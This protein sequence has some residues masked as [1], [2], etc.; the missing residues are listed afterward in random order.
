MGE[1]NDLRDLIADAHAQLVLEERNRA[2]RVL[3]D[4]VVASAGAKEKELFSILCQNLRKITDAEIAALASFSSHDKTLHLEAIDADPD[5]DLA[6]DGSCI[7]NTAQLDDELI[8]IYQYTQV[9]DC[10]RPD[11]CLTELFSGL[12]F[13]GIPCREGATRYSVSCVCEGQLVAAGIIQMRPKQALRMKDII[14]TYLNLSAMLIQRFN[15]FRVT[16]EN[17]ERTRMV[18]DNARAGIILVDPEKRLVVDANEVA[19][20]LCACSK[21]ELINQ[22]CSKFFCTGD[23]KKCPVRDLGETLY[24]SERKLIDANGEEHTTLKTVTPINIYGREHFIESFIDITEL[25]QVETALREREEMLRVVLEST[26]DGLVALDDEGHVIIANERAWD[27]WRIPHELRLNRDS[28]KILKT[29]LSQVKNPDVM[30]QKIRALL[31]TPET[32]FDIIHFKDGGTFEQL[33]RPLKKDGIVV[34]RL[35]SFRD[36]TERKR[37]EEEKNKLNEQLRQSQK[38]EAI[39]RL[40]GGVAHDF[41]N[42]LTGIN[43]YSEV[44]MNHLPG[45]DPLRN[46]MQEIIKAAKRA[47]SLTQQLLAFSRKQVI[48]P[49]VINLNDLV[50]EDEKMLSRIIGEHIKLSF[51]PADKL[52]SIRAD[53]GQIEQILFNLVVNARDAMPNGGKLIIETSNAVLDDTFCQQHPEAVPGEYVMLAVTDTGAG[54]DADTIDHVFEPFFTTKLNEEGTGLGLATVYGIVKQNE[55]FIYVYSEID[56]GTTF[57]VYLRCVKREA[58]TIT[59]QSKQEL[60]RGQETV[61]LVEDEEMVRSLA[62]RVLERSGYR[63]VEAQHGDEA[64]MLY[65]QKTD[66][67]D[68]LLTDVIMPNMNGKDLADRLQQMQPGIRVVF[69]SGYTADTIGHHGVLEE[70]VHFIQKPFTIDGLLQTLHT[71]LHE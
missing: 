8:E 69:M 66:H 19:A 61:L 56:I 51:L 49:K 31:K 41:N 1:A 10:A 63:V 44:I 52:G 26:A 2:F 29:V 38:M 18:W 35:W 46:D 53:R 13:Q 64:L 62:K 9:R 25:K 7:G 60:P 57:K 55:G 68:L 12:A 34:G 16:Q 20:N 47:T 28:R 71:A 70:G 5:A 54:M 11:M 39:G 21:E 22:P 40:A 14:D 59:S 37:S 17:E 3:Y 27:M 30:K 6:I 43:G 50:Q 45:D 58:D 24:N 42:L 15:L 36:I 33:S 32:S 23:M 4:T 67:I 65:Q 48:A